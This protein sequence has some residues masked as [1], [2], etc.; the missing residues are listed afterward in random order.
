VTTIVEDKTRELDA[1]GTAGSRVIAGTAVTLAILLAQYSFSPVALNERVITS[2]G[3][4]GT[5]AQTQSL[6]ITAV[7]LFN[8]INRVYDD[9]LKNQTELD[10]DAKHALYVN[11]WDLYT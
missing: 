9:I 4:Q 6:Q 11:L 2:L 1:A 7:H 10:R 8:Q 3:T 5:L